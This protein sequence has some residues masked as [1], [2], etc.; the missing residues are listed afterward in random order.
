MPAFLTLP[1]SLANRPLLVPGRPQYLFGTYSATTSPT[2]ANITNISAS[3]N[4]VTITVG[5][6]AGVP[7]TTAQLITVQGASNSSINAV[8]ATVTGV[9]GFTTGDLSTGTIAYTVNAVGTIASAAGAGT[10]VLP[11]AE[12]AD[13]L[14]SSL[15]SLQVTVP[16]ND[17]R[18]DQARTVTAQVS[19]PSLPTSVVVTLQDSDDDQTYYDV[20][21]VA[22]V[23]AGVQTGGFLQVQNS[24]ARFYRL[25]CGT[26]VGGSSPTIIGKVSA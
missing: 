9:S 17:P 15:I 22:S 1:A 16:F 19:F 20:A 21:T 14:T 11:V 10:V 25:S 6:T 18:I 24:S 13:A 4:T 7:P 2:L 8:G 3:V 12:T 26:V 5:L 23:A